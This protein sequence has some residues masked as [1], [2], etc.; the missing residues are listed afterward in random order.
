MKLICLALVSLPICVF[1]D[2][3]LPSQPYI[4]VE[5]RA[6]TEKPADF[7]G[8]RFQVVGR[9]A[10]RAKANEEVQAK[11]NKVLALFK[12]AKIAD[13]DIVAEDLSSEP[14]YEAEDLTRSRSKLIGY[15][16]TRP[17]GVNVR[18]IP[19]FSKLVD[20]LIGLGGIE[21]NHIEGGL[22][23][24]TEIEDQLWQKAL[25][26]A[27]ERA[28]K[29][30][31]PMGMKI[32]SVFAVSPIGFPEIQGRLLTNLTK[33]VIVTGSNVPPNKERVE[34][35]QYRLAPVFVSRTVNVIYLISPAK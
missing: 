30:L 27:R 16:V 33:D 10:E 2:G 25:T 29:T 23:K 5:G 18:H 8:L 1:A 12:E 17:V 24:Y 3:G 6:E 4:Y 19:R 32:D 20:Q 7:V 11:V 34:P 21:F 13:S 35:S 14:E 26:N 22:S 28:E 31:K 15:T 9:N